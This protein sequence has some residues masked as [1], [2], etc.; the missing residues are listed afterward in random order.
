M[1]QDWIGKVNAKFKAEKRN[2]VLLL[3]NAPTHLLVDVPK[4]TVQGFQLY[5]LSNVTLL[6]L[7]ANTT[8]IVQPLDQGIIAA[9]KARYR[10]HLVRATL[11]ELEND[12]DLTI[13]KIKPNMLNV[14]KWVRWSAKALTAETIRNCWF[15]AGI[16]GTD[17]VPTPPPRSVR[18]HIARHGHA[19]GEGAAAMEEQDADD[20]DDVDVVEGLDGEADNLEALQTDLEQLALAV[21]RHPGALEVGDSIITAGDYGHL[22]GEE[23]TFEELTD[24][25]IVELVMSDQQEGLVDEDDT[26]PEGVIVQK[27]TL[28]ECMQMLE[29]V[30][31]ALEDHA[32]FGMDDA[33]TLHD[34]SQRIM[35]VVMQHSKQGTLNGFLN[36][37]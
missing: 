23:E 16:L 34:L 11:A 15:K 5:Y 25:E 27:A 9:F 19:A 17:K 14:L 29:A 31:L 36:F 28:P 7:P 20:H 4:Q 18:R 13:A 10:R 3:D 35:R 8:S 6:F 2:I 24:E 37:E 21:R 33:D 32:F 26:D 1:L 12:N 30:E 22:A